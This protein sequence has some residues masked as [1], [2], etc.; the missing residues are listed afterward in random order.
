MLF[1]AGFLKSIHNTFS[2]EQPISNTPKDIETFRGQFI[3]FFSEDENPQVLYNSFL[4]EEAYKKAKEIEEQVGRTPVVFRV[5][6]NPVN[7]ISQ[8][9]ITRF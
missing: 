2:M 3:V 6:E 4:A 7:N 9:L 1:F 5:Q 8:V